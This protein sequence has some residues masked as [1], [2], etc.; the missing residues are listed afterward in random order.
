MKEEEVEAL[1]A[2]QEDSNGCI[3]Y[4]GTASLLSLRIDPFPTL[5]SPSLLTHV[6]IVSKLPY[7]EM[8]RENRYAELILEIPC[9]LL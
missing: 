5:F 1:L 8:L 7:S 6:L 2:G 4:E 3:N 9:S